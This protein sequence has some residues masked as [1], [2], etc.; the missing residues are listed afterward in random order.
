[1]IPKKK[2]ISVIAS[3]KTITPE[4]V[5]RLNFAKKLKEHYGNKIDFYGRGFNNMNDKLDA[6]SDYRFNVVLENSNFDDYFTEKFTDCVIA[7]TFPIYWGCPNLENYFPT[8]SFVRIDINNFNQSIEVIDTVIKQE[9]DKINREKLG[10]A[11]DLAMR[12]HNIFP[13]LVDLIK[14]IAAGKF[15]KQPKRFSLNRDMLLLN[16]ALYYK[17]KTIMGCLKYL[18]GKSFFKV[19]F[20]FYKITKVKYGRFNK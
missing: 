13:M 9:F 18:V 2:L 7:G 16:S 15:E 12:K 1:M 6:L 3:N 17:Q 4:H 8:S 10:I 14:N 20:N 11:R 5:K 19:L